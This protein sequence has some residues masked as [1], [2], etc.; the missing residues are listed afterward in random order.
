M[1]TNTEQNQKREDP[2]GKGTRDN[3]KG[4]GKRGRPRGKGNR[5]TQPAATSTP[6]AK[7]NKRKTLSRKKTAQGGAGNDGS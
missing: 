1:Q 3:P 6:A 7:K 2:K 4:K 5:N